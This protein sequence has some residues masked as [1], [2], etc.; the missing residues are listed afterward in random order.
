VSKVQQRQQHIYTAHTPRGGRGQRLSREGSGFA[1]TF[2]SGDDRY[3]H[4]TY[5][6]RQQQHYHSPLYNR[7]E[8][9]TISGVGGTRRRGRRSGTS[10][11]AARTRSGNVRVRQ[12]G[13]V[14]TQRLQNAQRQQHALRN[15]HSLPASTGGSSVAA[16]A[17]TWNQRV[18][19]PGQTKRCADWVST[20]LANSGARVRRSESAAGLATQGAPV[21]RANLRPGD[22]IFFGNT[23]RKGKY[24]H[25]GIYMG[26]GKFQHRPTSNRPVTVGSLDSGYWSTRFTGGR[27]FM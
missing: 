24:T 15:G 25:V 5:G 12:H 3:A 1:D 13:N 21:G 9:G 27:R 17:R 26:D 7:H 14:R 6:P 8:Q 23:Y 10:R 4:L 2:Q 20:V 19:K 22:A 18:F 16:H 11:S